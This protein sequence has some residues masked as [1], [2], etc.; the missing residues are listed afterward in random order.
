M[1]AHTNMTRRLL[2]WSVPLTVGAVLGGLV[3]GVWAWTGWG[4]TATPVAVVDVNRTG[5]ALLRLASQK[6]LREVQAAV[7]GYARDLAAVTQEL[8]KDKGWVIV[9]SDGIL[10][11]GTEIT[12]ATDD[13]LEALE[14]R[15]QRVGR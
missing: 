15:W 8:A 3:Y 7:D 1:Q 12:D 2:S 10:A 4:H 9:R 14:K 6:P 13:V 11:G 5:A